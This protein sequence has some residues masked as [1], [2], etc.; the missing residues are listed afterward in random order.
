MPEAT[1]AAIITTTDDDGIKVLLTRRKIEPFKGYWCLPGGHI[2]QYEAVEV[3]IAREV[4]EETGLSFDPHFFRYF[5]ERFPERD[6]HAVVIAFEGTGQGQLRAQRKEVSKI[7]WFPLDQALTMP[8]AFTHNEILK[9][10][11]SSLG[12]PSDKVHAEILAEYSALRAEITQRLDMRQQILTFTLIIAGTMLSLGTQ[13][14]MTPA[15]LLIYPVLALFLA[16]S[17]MQHDVRIAEMAK[18]LEEKIEPRC[19]G[20]HWESYIH[21]RHRGSRFRPVEVTATGIFL[22]TQ[23]LTVILALPRLRYSLDE[24]ILLV[25]A[26]PAV[27]FTILSLRS[28]FGMLKK[29]EQK[30]YVP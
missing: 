10:F 17:W 26:V 14:D 27:I 25:A 3:A 7:A 4:R 20:L 16:R 24:I 30:S 2:D 9:A 28:R 1:V 13:K 5:D 6:I 19:K 29:M 15:V 21:S 18:F 11:A 22:A 12:S 23:I 8:L